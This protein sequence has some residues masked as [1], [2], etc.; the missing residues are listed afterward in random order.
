MDHKGAFG[1]PWLGKL[2][3]RDTMI[4]EVKLRLRK[5]HLPAGQTAWDHSHDATTC[6][7]RRYH[8]LLNHA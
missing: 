3:F 2:W 5:H 8:R 1:R 6:D 4:D 7:R